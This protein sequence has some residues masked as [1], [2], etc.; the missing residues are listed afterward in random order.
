MV[1][2]GA[3]ELGLALEWQYDFVL[4]G[5]QLR[6][7]KDTV[8]LDV[9]GALGPGVLDHH[10]TQTPNTSTAQL[11]SRYP[12]YVYEHLLGP[13][14]RRQDDGQ[15]LQGRCWSPVI[16]T[17]KAP[18]LDA[19]SAAL[20]VRKLLEDGELPRWASSLEQFVTEV[21]LGRWNPSPDGEQSPIVW[22]WPSTFSMRK[23]W[24]TDPQMCSV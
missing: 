24:A 8:L 3:K 14:L 11:V 5:T 10:G 13:W 17:H 16:T 7:R 12:D 1:R 23:R 22:R 9:G 6:V 2:R 21:D 20:L 4:P 19:C 15:D 18:D